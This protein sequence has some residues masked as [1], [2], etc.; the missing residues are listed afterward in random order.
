MTQIK[1]QAPRFDSPPK[2]KR[3][4][5][6]DKITRE[7]NKTIKNLS[8][9]QLKEIESVLKINRE[10]PVSSQSEQ[11]RHFPQIKQT[12][13]KVRPKSAFDLQSS[14]PESVFSG[15]SES[16]SETKYPSNPIESYKKTI[17]QPK[18]IRIPS[19][20]TRELMWRP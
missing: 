13:S 8:K 4:A 6:L 16:P 15:H 10:A 12:K 20:G 14:R 7:Q 9:S 11:R 5:F 18:A 1:H 3:V 2:N 17:P 19:H